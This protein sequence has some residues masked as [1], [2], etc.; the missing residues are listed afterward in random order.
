MTNT[1]TID[2]LLVI[3]DDAD[4]VTHRRIEAAEAI[5]GFEAPEAAVIRARE[6]LIEIFENAEEQIGDRMDALKASRK[7]EAAKVNPKIV[8][9]TRRTE[10]DRREAW[11]TYERWLR[12]R[13]LIKKTRMP[14]LPGWDDDLLSDK[15]LPPPGDDWPPTNVVYQQGQGFRILHDR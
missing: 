2:A 8:H 1:R 15:Y 5:L 6:F 3:M 4:L 9:L 7:A 14:P 11:R 10:M 12:R 13:E